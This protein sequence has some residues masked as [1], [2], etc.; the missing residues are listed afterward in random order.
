M[1]PL[2]TKSFAGSG[3]EVGT[4]GVCDASTLV[5][6]RLND[7]A[8]VHGRKPGDE[9]VTD[10]ALAGHYCDTLGIAERVPPD[11]APEAVQATDVPE[12]PAPRTMKGPA[13]PKK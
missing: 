13:R 1:A 9:F 12:A 7:K 2:N 6:I 10:A 8:N 5:K 3:H 4:P 11:V